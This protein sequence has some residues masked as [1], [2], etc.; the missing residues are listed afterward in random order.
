MEGS[1][2]TWTPEETIRDMEEGIAKFGEYSFFD[3]GPAEVMNIDSKIDFLK[4]LDSR[5]CHDF[6]KKIMEDANTNED[7]KLVLASAL[8]VG[9]EDGPWTDEEFQYICDACPEGY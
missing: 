6:I 5:I 8:L 1:M 7:R 4:T 2:K 3:K 9:I